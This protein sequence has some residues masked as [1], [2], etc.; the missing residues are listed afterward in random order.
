MTMIRSA[1]LAAALLSSAPASAA[2]ITL[3]P[4]KGETLAASVGK[5]A[6]GDTVIALPGDHGAPAIVGAMTPRVQIVCRPGAVIGRTTITKA[7]G[8]LFKG[9]DFRGAANEPG[10]NQRLVQ[11]DLVSSDIDFDRCSFASVENTSGWTPQDWVDRPYFL[12]LFLRG[13]NMNVSNSHFFNL[14]NALAARADNSRVMNNTF[15]AFGNDAMQIGASGLRIVGNT[16]RD[17]RH[18]PVDPL[19][20]DA[21]QGYPAPKDG[22]YSDVLIE[23]NVVRP[24]PRGD[25]LQGISAFDGRW[26]NVVI[27]GNRVATQAYHGITWFGVNSIV[28][29]GNTVEPVPGVKEVPWIEVAPAKNGRPSTGVVVRANVTPVLRLRPLGLR[30]GNHTA[31]GKAHQ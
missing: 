15:E 25:Y 12:G 19:H 7:M 27:R 13:T 11:T 17:G 5:I 21:I 22:L 23:G 10:N 30:E 14:R 9:C 4:A 24:S 6:P 16:I 28:I 3:D 2:T 18:T 26:Q 31:A 20:A 29:E 1:V 8:W